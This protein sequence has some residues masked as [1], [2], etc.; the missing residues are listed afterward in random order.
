MA[1]T[2]LNFTTATEHTRTDSNTATEHTERNA[3]LQH[4]H[5][6]SLNDRVITT[7]HLYS[8]D[9]HYEDSPRRN[10]FNAA[11]EHIRIG[12]CRIHW[13][14][15]YHLQLVVLAELHHEIQDRIRIPGMPYQFFHEV[16][17]T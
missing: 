15:V 9:L 8:D 3:F 10:I 1:N 6:T 16:E 12:P 13:S 2:P 14:K 5:A 4:Q 11:T 17:L 7:L